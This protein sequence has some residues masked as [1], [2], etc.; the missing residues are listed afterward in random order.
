LAFKPVDRVWC[1]YEKLVAVCTR[2]FAADYRRTIANRSNNVA[3]AINI[4]SSPG[5]HVSFRC[6]MLRCE[7]LFRM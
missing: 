2:N 4:N 7:G 6:S 5:N 1:V 3:A